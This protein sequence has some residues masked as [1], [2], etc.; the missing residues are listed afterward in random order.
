[1]KKTIIILSAIA[2][3]AGNCYA[4][5]SNYFTTQDTVI[6]T[7]KIEDISLKLSKE[8]FNRIVSNQSE[9][10]MKN[11]WI[12]NPDNTYLLRE[13]KDATFGGEAGQNIYYIL[14]YHFVKNDVY[15][16]EEGK[17]LINIFLNINS[18]FQKLENGGT[19]FGHQSVRI[20]A[21][22]AYATYELDCPARELKSYDISKQKDLYIQSLRQLIQDE[23][24]TDQFLIEEEKV[25][26]IKEL[27]KIVDEIEKSITNIFYLRKAQEFHYKYYGY[28]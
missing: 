28:Y 5:N 8:E 25:Q 17:S 3:L 12:D 7:T 11:N 26:K 2:L 19:F 20:L 9:L 14:Y 15:Y 18:L 27:N 16:E 22:S 21:Y 1:M 4:Q 6:I 24:D 13:Y 23:T 10:L